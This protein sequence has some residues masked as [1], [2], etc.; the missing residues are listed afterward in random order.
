[1]TDTGHGGGR[2][3]VLLRHAKA[4]PGGS[5]PDAMRPLAL[6]GRTQAVRLGPALLAE[7]LVPDRVLVSGA[8]RTRQTWELARPGLG[9]ADPAVET[10]DDLYAAGVAD[11]LAMVAA[12]DASVGTLLVVGHEP[13]MSGVASRLAG[14]GSDGAALA[15]VQVGVPTASYSVLVSDAAWDAWGPGAA[16][17][18]HLGRPEA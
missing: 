2:R 4:E 16:R 13:V 12:T 15:Q 11:V 6:Q 8:V 7:G 1:M 18:V 5:V 3:L 9:G 17:L 10:T 14:D